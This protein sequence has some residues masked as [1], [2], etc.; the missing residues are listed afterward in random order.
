MMT[1]ITYVYKNI[2]RI[3]IDFI[4]LLMFINRHDYINR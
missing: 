2:T 1:K 4:F 3:Q